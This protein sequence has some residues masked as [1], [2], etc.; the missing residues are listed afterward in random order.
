[1][2]ERGTVKR[3]TRVETLVIAVVCLAVILS[4]PVL[5][6][7]T[8]KAADRKRC[9]ANLAQIGKAM[10]LYAADYEGALP[11]AG[12]PTTT[13]GPTRN[14]VARNRHAAFGLDADANGGRAT[15]SSS[16]YLL[17]KYYATPTKLFACPSDK[18]TTAFSLRRL[19]GVVPNFTFARAWD[20]GPSGESFKHSSYSYHMPYGSFALTT[21][22]DPNLAVAADRNP[23]IGSPEDRARVVANFRP[24]VDPYRGT[25][26]QGRAGN[27]VSH[28][29]D[30][31]NVL[32]L[33]QRVTFEKR[34]FCAVGK[35][36]IYLVSS[37]PDKGCVTG[38]VP[39]PA[40]TVVANERDSVLVHDPAT[41]GPETTAQKP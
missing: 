28:D 11:R 5:S 18:G 6:G 25:P 20:F 16:L 30:G 12:G 3:L 34:P 22:R 2:A 8:R 29:L 33:D 26:E 38:S 13:W 15:V 19:V 24:D 1:M 4:V 21:S 41:F 31:Q 39:I 32:F 35:D 27:A 40:G 17:V 10:F 37:F 7:K 36:N 9:A 14:W 23:V